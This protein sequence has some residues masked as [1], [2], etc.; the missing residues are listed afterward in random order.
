MVVYTAS[1]RQLANNASIMNNIICS[2]LLTVS[3]H[4]SVT[5]NYYRII[6]RTLYAIALF[7]LKLYPALTPIL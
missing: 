2:E 1:S 4:T 5:S 7:P 6:L 3:G